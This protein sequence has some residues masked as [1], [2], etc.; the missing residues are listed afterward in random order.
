M[1]LRFP[2]AFLAIIGT[3]VWLSHS[4]A[5]AA[6]SLADLESYRAGCQSLSDG[7]YETATEVLAGLPVVYLTTVGRKSGQPRR[8]PLI[9]VP[10]GDDLA[11]LAQTA[12]QLAQEELAPAQREAETLRVR[13]DAAL[14]EAQTVRAQLAAAQSDVPTGRSGGRV[15]GLLLLLLLV[16]AVGYVLLLGAA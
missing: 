6:G 13:L 3:A 12:R 5:N 7:R 9:A 2:A 14:S 11:L 15:A 4:P 10:I 8:T 16:A 1:I